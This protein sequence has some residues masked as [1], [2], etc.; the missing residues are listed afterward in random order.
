MANAIAFVPT[1]MPDLTVWYG[2]LSEA[3]DT[4]IIIEDGTRRSEYIG[5]FSYSILGSVSG[6]LETVNYY[7]N[8]V[9]QYSVTNVGADAGA[10]Y[11]AVQIQGDFELAAS[12]VLAGD[13]VGTGSSGDDQ[14]SS[15]GGNDTLFGGSGSD[16]LMG[17][18]G[19]DSLLGQSGNDELLGQAGDDDLLGS[20]GVDTLEGGSGN[21]VLFGGE[22]TDVFRFSGQIDQDRIED[23]DHASEVLE[24]SIEYGFSSIEDV[25]DAQMRPSAGVTRLTLGENQWVD[26]LDTTSGSSLSTAN[27]RFFDPDATDTV[28]EG[29]DTS[30]TLPVGSV[31]LGIIDAEPILGDGPA[32]RPAV[33]DGQG[34]RVDKDWYRVTLEADRTYQ[35]RAESIN[36]TSD[37]VFARLF[38]SAGNAVGAGTEAEGDDAI[39]TFETSGQTGAQDYYLAVSAGDTNN[40]D[41]LT[42]TGRFLVSLFDLGATAADTVAANVDTSATIEVDT[43]QSGEIQQ[44]DVGGNYFDAD[45]YRVSLEGGQQYRIAADANP[46]AVSDNLDELFIR[47]RDADGAPISP[48]FSDEG[49]AP[50]ILFN[51]AGNGMQDFYVAVSAG[52]SGAWWSK[53]GSYSLSVVGEGA[54]PPTNYRPTAEATDYEGD[55]GEVVLLTDVFSYDDRD[56]L[57][58]VTSFVI[59]DRT[60]E[61]GYLTYL[62]KKQA[63]NMPYTRPIEELDDWAFVVGESGSDYVGFNVID[64]DGLFNRSVVSEVSVAPEMPGQEL[65]RSAEELF[66]QEQLSVLAD[67]AYAAYASNDAVDQLRS[68]GWTIVD[69]DYAPNLG[70]SAGRIQGD[71]FYSGEGSVSGRASALLAESEDGLS[72]VIAFTGTDSNIEVALDWPT[73]TVAHF[74]HYRDLLREIDYSR[75]EKIY[76]TGHSMGGAMAQ[77]FATANQ[78]RDFEILGIDLVTGDA[79]DVEGV[80]F[81]NPGYNLAPAGLLFPHLNGFANVRA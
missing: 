42:T 47:I 81:A 74:P 53:T 36:M 48:D 28:R 13:D 67:F 18:E 37:S 23:F 38:D 45:Y 31:R 50:E 21:D 65:L 55:P 4:T 68:A 60:A 43:T 34:G 2:F 9:Q 20:E 64:T 15:F 25:L 3:S 63:P 24:I 35:F 40:S 30:A 52:G 39:F 54:A 6:V 58:D 56:G 69:S 75:Y 79:L 16:R 76:V 41:F 71:H 73:A 78:I 33:D 10:F 14:V 26:I 46:G 80:T 27:I 70:I 1:S 59:Q 32:D 61:S 44:F 5:S 11:N 66:G 7:E 62:G 17:G 22:N 8:G 77:A 12:I 19:N 51:A 49:A 29:T 72:L 57:S